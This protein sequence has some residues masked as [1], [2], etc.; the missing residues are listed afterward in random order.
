MPAHETKTSTNNT[1]DSPAFQRAR[2]PPTLRTGQLP[3]RY[4]HEVSRRVITFD[5]HLLVRFAPWPKSGDHPDDHKR[6]LRSQTQA[7]GDVEFCLTT[8]FA[9]MQA[10]VCKELERMRAINQSP[11]RELKLDAL[12]ARSLMPGHNTIWRA[13]HADKVT[14]AELIVAVGEDNWPRV[15]RSFLRRELEVLEVT[16]T[17]DERKL[18]GGKLVRLEYLPWKCEYP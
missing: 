12:L 9:E 15:L 8:T 5:V 17:P 11:P 14:M 13:A 3:P 10:S 7:W 2:L 16:L 6:Y 1:R 4:N 18:A